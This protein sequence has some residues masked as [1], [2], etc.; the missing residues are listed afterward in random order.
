MLSSEIMAT[1]IP[2]LIAYLSDKERAQKLADKCG[3]SVAYLKHLAYGHR[4][5][6]PKL[7]KKIE[8][9]SSVTRRRLRPDFYEGLAA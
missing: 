8:R 7:A 9:Y 1:Q 4:K 3:T 5:A 6:S 2:Q